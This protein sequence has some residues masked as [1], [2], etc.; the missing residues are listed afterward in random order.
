VSDIGD[1]IVDKDAHAHAS[2]LIHGMD[3]CGAETM[4]D[5]L[6]GVLVQASD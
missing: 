4:A 5:D 1:S 6:Y 3:V 2:G